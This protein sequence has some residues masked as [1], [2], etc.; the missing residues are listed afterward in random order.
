MVQMLALLI[1]LVANIINWT[2]IKTR[3][4]VV[5]VPV[6]AV[7]VFFKEWYEAN[8]LIVDSI[9]MTLIVGITVSWII[10]LVSHIQYKKR[11]RQRDVAYV[12]SQYGEPVVLTKREQ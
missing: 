11:Q 8:T 1:I 12:Y 6:S 7:F 9:G 5:V 4:Y 2:I 3:L 10:T